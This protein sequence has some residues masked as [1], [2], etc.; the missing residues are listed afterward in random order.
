MS[1]NFHKGSEHE[2]TIEKMAFGGKG[3]TR[4]DNFVLF[5][6]GAIPGSTVLARVTKAKKR[7]AEAETVKV[8]DPGPHAATPF[9]LHFGKCGGC[10]F[11]DLD[12]TE[13]VRWKTE[14]VRETLSRIA[15][16]EDVMV[17]DA[18]PSPGQ[19]FYRNKME[20]AFSGGGSRIALG[21]HRRASTSIVNVERCE[22]Q[23]QLSMDVVRQAREF[24]RRVGVPAY[25]PR[26]RKGVWRYLVVREAHATQ[27]ALVNVITSNAPDG[28]AARAL[29]EDLLERFPA[30]TGAVHSVRTANSAVAQGQRQAAAFGKPHIE[31]HLLGVKFHISADAFFQT[32]T[33]AAELLYEA[34]LDMAGLTG[35]EHVLDLYCGV[36]GLALCAAGRAASVLGVENHEPSVKD[37]R[38]NAELNGIENCEFVAGD[39]R[40]TL[41]ELDH[42]PDVAF[43]DPPRSGMH[44]E[45]V[46]S[47]A[48]L[49]PRRIV[50]V[51]CNPATL[52]RD[53]G[54]FAENGYAVAEARPVDLFPHGPHIECAVRLE[55]LK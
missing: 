32:N 1:E 43:V 42:A 19:R 2:L 18:V 38:A 7:F 53:A 24:C 29:C 5:V 30:L 41:A 54:L 25:D 35:S 44:P 11:Q 10:L 55:R 46:T 39:T 16:A 8:L 36:G 50:Y 33:R 17:H 40:S 4:V 51:S 21:L 37:A 13:Q 15:G 52:A 14:H 31:E 34:A 45:A 48:A 49:A 9:C 22:L 47:L 12:Y 3:L 26:T 6:D 23:S 27:Q 20:F 28:G